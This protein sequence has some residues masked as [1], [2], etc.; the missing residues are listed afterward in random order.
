M[1]VLFYFVIVQHDISSP[2]AFI[3]EKSSQDIKQNF[4]CCVLPKKL[5]LD[6]YGGKYKL[7]I[8]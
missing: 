4:F 8:L 6:Q 2:S 5:G 3:M 1:I 7:H